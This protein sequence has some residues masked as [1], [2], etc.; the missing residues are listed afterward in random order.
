MTCFPP[1]PFS[2]FF[3]S[4]PSL[5]I[6]S[7]PPLFP[8]SFSLPFAS[9]MVWTLDACSARISFHGFRPFF[10]E[11]AP[12]CNILPPLTFKTFDDQGWKCF[13]S[14]VSS[15]PSSSNSS[16]NSCHFLDLFLFDRTFGR[17]LDGLFLFFPPSCIVIFIFP[18]F[19]LVP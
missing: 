5:R 9:L 18:F 2:V 19:S 1:N 15:P 3:P 4:F 14:F 13:L 12:L 10:S 8:R 6:Y 17:R 16:K 7:M 11:T